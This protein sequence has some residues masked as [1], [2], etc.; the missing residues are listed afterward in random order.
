MSWPCAGK[1]ATPTLSVTVPAG[2]RC[3][4]TRFLI[5]SAISVALVALVSGIS[6]KNSSP[7]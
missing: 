2:S 3:S 7:P 5:R 6:T 4:A 1:S